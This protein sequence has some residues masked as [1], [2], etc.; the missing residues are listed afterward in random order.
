MFSARKTPV[1]FSELLRYISEDDILLKYL[2][3]PQIPCLINS[4]FRDDKNPS[5]SIYYDKKTGKIRWRDFGTN[6]SGGIFDLLMAI[7][8]LS[9]KELAEKIEEDFAYNT[10]SIDKTSFDSSRSHHKYV[11][12]K[13]IKL[14]VRIRKWKSWD[15]EYWNSY[16]ISIDLLEKAR[17]YPISHLFVEKNGK[18]IIINSDKHAYVYVE[19]KDNIPT[20]KIYQPYSTKYKWLNRHDSSVWS[21]W[22]MLPENGEKLIITSST[23]DALCIIENLGIPSCSLQAES[24]LPKPKVIEELKQRF[25]KIYIL[26]DND[27][28]KEINYGHQY[29]QKIAETF[30]LI[31]IEIPTEYKSKD[32]S[33]LY[34]NHGKETFVNVISKLII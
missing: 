15:I 8:H 13:D 3:I 9:F 14:D 12:D 7:Y 16:G 2:N 27:F 19:F 33:D 20:Y 17:V 10:S 21:L 28:T 26:Y 25:Q 18:S 30:D 4:P 6:E 11:F 1:D 32:P 29:G 24:Y 31:Q 34:K 5:F 23:K 22:R